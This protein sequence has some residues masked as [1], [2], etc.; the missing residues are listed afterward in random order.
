MADRRHCKT[1]SRLGDAGHIDKAPTKRR[2]CSE[3]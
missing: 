3:K 1:A 2:F